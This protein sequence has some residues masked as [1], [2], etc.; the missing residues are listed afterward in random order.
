VVSVPLAALRVVKG[1]RQLREYR[2][3]TGTAKHFFCEVCGIYTHHQRRSS[4]NQ[5]GVN[6][7]CLKGVNPYDLP[8]VP[9]VDGVNHPSDSGAPPNNQSTASGPGSIGTVGSVIAR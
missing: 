2:F 3:N 8:N 9:V 1:H 7:G 6:L 5:F 4:P